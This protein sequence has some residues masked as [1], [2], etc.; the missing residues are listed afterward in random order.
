M[1]LVS[2]G[3]RGGFQNSQN[4]GFGLT[5]TFP[6]VKLGLGIAATHILCRYL[7]T[8][9]ALESEGKGPLVVSY[10]TGSYDDDAQS[11]SPLFWKRVA[12][13]TEGSFKRAPQ[14]KT[15]VIVTIMTIP[16]GIN[17]SLTV[18]TVFFPSAVTSKGN[19]YAY[20]T[21]QEPRIA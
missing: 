11:L 12:L 19:R 21:T 7:S 9:L 17:T 4:P 1:T 16:C 20:S 13:I 6:A 2:R 10:I 14:S 18:L 3:L 8:P 15:Y 5:S